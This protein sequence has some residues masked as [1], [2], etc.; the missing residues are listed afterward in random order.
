MRIEITQDIW[1]AKLVC[2]VFFPSIC[3]HMQEGTISE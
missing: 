1:L 2:D 3:F